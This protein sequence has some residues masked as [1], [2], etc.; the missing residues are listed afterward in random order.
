MRLRIV[1]IACETAR[2]LVSVSADGFIVTVQV[3]LRPDEASYSSNLSWIKIRRIRLSDFSVGDLPRLHS[4]LQHFNGVVGINIDRIVHLYLQDQVC[5]AFEIQPQVNAVLKRS[6][7]RAPRSP[8]GHAEDA[9]N[10]HQQG[11][12][13]DDKF[14]A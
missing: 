4:C 7:Q 11:A 1:S 13:D 6:Q 5:P 12:D 10:K 9:V 3:L 8:A 14:A 2:F